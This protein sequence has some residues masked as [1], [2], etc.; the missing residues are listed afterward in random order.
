MPSYRVCFINEIPRGRTPFRC[1]QR[2]IAVR[3][4]RSSERVIKAA[5]KWL[6]PLEH[7]CN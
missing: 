6:T 3:S 1:C 7:I 2:S 5:K 4:T